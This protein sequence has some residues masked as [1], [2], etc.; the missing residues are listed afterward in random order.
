MTHIINKHSDLDDP[1]FNKC[2]HGEIGPKKWLTPGTC[3]NS[4]LSFEV[5]NKTNVWLMLMQLNVA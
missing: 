5:T 3:S 1:V 2:S 4:V